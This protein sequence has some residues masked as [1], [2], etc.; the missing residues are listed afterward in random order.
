MNSTLNVQELNPVIL[1]DTPIITK[2]YHL[3]DI[4]VKNHSG[5]HIEEYLYIFNKFYE[6]IKNDD[7][8]KNSLIVICGDTLDNRTA[9]SIAQKLA[10]DFIIE[11]SKHTSVIIIP[12]NHQIEA[13]DF[14]PE[15]Q[16]M[17]SLRDRPN[18]HLLIKS[19]FYV[20][21]NLVFGVSS[22]YDNKILPI[23]KDS[24]KDKIKISLFHGFFVNEYEEEYKK[25][26]KN[27][28]CLKSSDVDNYDLVLLG[29]THKH[30]Y[31]DS[32][33]TICYSGSFIQLHVGESQNKGYVLWNLKDM[34]SEFIEIQNIYGHTRLNIDD[35]GEITDLPKYLPPRTRV[36]LFHDN[37]PKE[38][39][40]EL[41]NEL[42]PERSS[43]CIRKTRNNF[44]KDIDIPED[45]DK[46]YELEYQTK[47]IIDGYK[48]KNPTIE[49]SELT[50]LSTYCKKVFDRTNYEKPELSNDFKLIDMT[51]SN[52]FG[53]Q[54]N[55]Y[56]KFDKKGLINIFGENAAGKTSLLDVLT[57]LM[58]GKYTRYKTNSSLLNTEKDHFFCSL[59]F[60]ILDVE[61][62]IIKT[63]DANK[64]K[65]KGVKRSIDVKVGL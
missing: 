26:Y 7:D 54:E 30:Q 48:K 38:K 6:H 45:Y 13:G 58:T 56:L 32:A 61:Y 36:R 39:C 15:G 46:I 27:E 44:I 47:L 2:L 22:L 60:S 62:K 65:E 35:S 19:N 28:T 1:N 29:D 50:K 24:F 59:R 4:H 34:S 53:Y 18:I 40:E 31:C 25:T 16:L 23:D 64:N 33:R 55:N 37:Y 41:I 21:A 63:G 51:F 9:N 49:E 5:V 57:F 8:I 20:Y 42:I 12:G 52:L 3:S 14:A 43:L 17:S 11:L 10:T